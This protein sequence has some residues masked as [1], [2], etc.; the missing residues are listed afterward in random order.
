[1]MDGNETSRKGYGEG[2]P[3]DK[4]VTGSILTT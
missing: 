2:K 1:M 4:K 3:E